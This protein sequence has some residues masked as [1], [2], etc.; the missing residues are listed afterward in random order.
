MVVK[1]YGSLRS[2]CT[3]RVLACFHEKG[4]EYEIVHVDLQTAQHKQPQFLLLQPFGQVPVIEEGEFRLFESRA[5]IRYYAAKY[6]DHGA[7]LLG[8]T[9]EERAIVDQWVEVESN[10]FNDIVYTLVLQILILPSM[11]K[12][13]NLA[14]VHDC[15]KKMAKVLDVYEERLGKSNYLG[16]DAFSLA[17]LSHLPGIRYL[18][19]E[20]NMEHLVSERK[21]VKAWWESIS[22]RPAWKKLINIIDH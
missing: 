17:D 7:D 4:I 5:I 2:A 8:A 13:G 10:N 12:K 15:E 16:G 11:G 21:N 18:V 20:V 9:T 14:L 22:N 3:Q 19:N 1:V 6:A